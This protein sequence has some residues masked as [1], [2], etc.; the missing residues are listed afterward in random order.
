MVSAGLHH[1]RQHPLRRP[2]TADDSGPGSPPAIAS[3]VSATPP[4]RRSCSPRRSTMSRTR[5]SRCSTLAAS[6]DIAPSARLAA[7]QRQGGWPPHRRLARSAAAPAPRLARCPVKVASSATT[8]RIIGAY[9]DEAG[10]VHGVS[11]TC[12]HLGCTRALERRRDHL[13]LPVSRLPLRPRRHRAAGPSGAGPA[14]HR[15]RRRRPPLTWLRRQNESRSRRSMTCANRR[16]DRWLRTWVAGS[17][18]GRTRLPIVLN[19]GSSWS[20]TTHRLSVP[21]TRNVATAAI[22]GRA[23]T[24]RRSIIAASSTSSTSRAVGDPQ[25][26]EPDDVVK[27]AALLGPP[28]IDACESLGRR[29]ANGVGLRIDEHAEGIPR[30]GFDLSAGERHRIRFVPARHSANPAGHR[31]LGFRSD[32]FGYSAR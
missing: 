11:L 15:G 10:A 27:L 3:G 5:G 25:R 14:T 8:D 6:A 16:S 18:T 9:R 17:I 24:S 31:P 13:G 19:A 30:G 28:R 26:A 1:G 7:R 21:I 29:R 2:P 12:T 23:R 22:N 4:R 32:R 20:V